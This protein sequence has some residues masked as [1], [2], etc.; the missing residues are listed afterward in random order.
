M[1]ADASSTIPVWTRKRYSPSSRACRSGAEDSA[2]EAEE[3]IR[4]PLCANRRSRAMTGMHDGRVGK[5]EQP[6]ERV[7]ERGGIRERQV[8]ATNRAGKEA[9]AP[10]HRTV[11]D[12]R[13]VPGRV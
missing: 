2:G 13:Y 12:E 5:P 7:L 4:P 8:R 6:F 10:E 9:I 3:R 1:R 11:P